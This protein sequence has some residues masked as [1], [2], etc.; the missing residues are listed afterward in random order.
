[1]HGRFGYGGDIRCEVE[2]IPTAMIYIQQWI[3]NNPS[4]EVLAQ[5]WLDKLK[6]LYPVETAN[7][8]D[9]G[10]IISSRKTLC[11]LSIPMTALQI[12]NYY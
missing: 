9:E 4:E 3:K 2:E 5:T 1:M 8:N 10:N 7:A 12:H 6:A 11:R